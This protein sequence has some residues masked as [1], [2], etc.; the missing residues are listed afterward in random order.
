M[1]GAEGRRGILAVC[2]GDRRAQ[3]SRNFPRAMPSAFR[4]QPSHSPKLSVRLQ[5]LSS[6]M[7][8]GL[9]TT[10]STS[11]IWHCSRKPEGEAWAGGGVSG[12]VWASE[13]AW[14]A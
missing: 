7:V 5:V 4:P 13:A 12:G 6:V 1:E 10:P 3:I 14:A 11:T 9:L 8:L 2:W